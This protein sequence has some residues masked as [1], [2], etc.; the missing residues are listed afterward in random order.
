MK[1]NFCKIT[2]VVF[3]AGAAVALAANPFNFTFPISELGNCGSVDACRAYCDILA[4]AQ[5]CADFAAAH[6]LAP[7]EKAKQA[8]QLPATGPGGCDSESSCRSYCDTAAH[9]QECL[10]FGTKHGLISKEDGVKAK[11]FLTQT[12]PGGCKGTACKR[13]CEDPA[14][15]DEC[16]QFAKDRKLISQSQAQQLERGQNLKRQVETA[17]GPGGCT[18]EDQCRQYCSDPSHEYEC[19]NFAAQF[20]NLTKEAAQNMLEELRKNKSDIRSGGSE[21]DHAKVLQEHCVEYGGAW[22]GARCIPPASAANAATSTGG[23]G[24]FPF[25]GS[26]REELLKQVQEHCAE[27]GGTWDG[28]LCL[29]P[30]SAAGAPSSRIGSESHL[31]DLLNIF[32]GVFFR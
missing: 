21:E 1:L 11:K 14:H 3:F 28:H 31:G 13:Y 32:F 10:D 8:R 6:G 12:G 17:G 20:G 30:A 26:S 16:L 18:T 23:S 25:N 19:A 7:K 27:Y 24:S 9:V 22:D 4:N 15:R 29:P 2:A 5:A